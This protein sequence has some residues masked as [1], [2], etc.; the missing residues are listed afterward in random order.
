MSYGHYD[1]IYA[2]LS[3]FISILFNCVMWLLTIVQRA[4]RVESATFEHPMHIV[5]S[6]YINFS[7]SIL[8]YS[9]IYIYIDKWT[10][11]YW[12][13][14][15]KIGSGCGCGSQ[16]VQPEI[17]YRFFAWQEIFFNPFY[18]FFFFI[19]RWSHGSSSIQ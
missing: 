18:L 11:I 17:G 1:Y 12:E 8:I 14:D 3:K 5:H 15:Q 19:P 2:P 13:Y 6:I 4:H 16:Y 9:F 10:Y 7:Q